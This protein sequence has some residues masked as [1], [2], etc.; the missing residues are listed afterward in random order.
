SN[1]GAV[2]HLD[3]VILCVIILTAIAIFT[4]KRKNVLIPYFFSI[5]LIPMGQVLALGSINFMMCRMIILMAWLRVLVTKQDPD[6]ER[7]ALNKI[8][9]LF[10]SYLIFSFL[11]FVVLFMTMPAFINRAGYLYSTGGGFFIARHLIRSR[12]DTDKLIRTLVYVC[13]V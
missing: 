10:F 6:S 2:S 4:V 1:S 12:E 11:T 3:P 9:K 7:Y 8:D 13:V 5:A